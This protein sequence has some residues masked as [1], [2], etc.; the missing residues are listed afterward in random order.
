MPAGVFQVV[1]AERGEV[2]EHLVFQ[3]V[4]VD[5]E[6]DGRFVCRRRAK[7]VVSAALIMVKVLPLP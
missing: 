2:L 4:A 3:L 1:Q 7:K 6:E 5:H